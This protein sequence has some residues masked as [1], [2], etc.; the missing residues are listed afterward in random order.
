MN[1]I[2]IRYA[3]I[4][5]ETSSSGTQHF[6]G[7]VEFTN[8]ISSATK[9]K[10]LLGAW[11]VSRRGSAEEADMYCRKGEQP[12][13]EWQELKWRGP[14]FGLNADFVNAGE[15]SL[16]E[17]KRTDLDEVVSL[18]RDGATLRT[19]VDAYPVQYIKYYRGIE[20]YMRL[21]EAPR[22]EV[23]TVTVFWGSS[24]IGK[25]YR[26]RLE[27]G[28]DCY[29]WHPQQESWFDGYDAHR[30][31]IFEEFR[32]QLPYGFVLSLTDR[33]DC[34]IQ[35]KGGSCQFLATSIWFTSPV[36]P[37]EWYNNL[38]QGD[39]YTQFERRLS[40]VV[41]VDE[42]VE[43][44]R[45]KR[46]C[47]MM[48]S[49]SRAQSE[50]DGAVPALGEVGKAFSATVPYTGQS[51]SETPS[52]REFA[53]D[54]M[55]KTWM[56]PPLTPLSTCGTGTE[57]T[58]VVPVVRDFST[59]VPDGFRVRASLGDGNCLFHSLCVGQSISACDLRHVNCWCTQR[60]PCKVDW[61]CLFS[62]V[63][64][65]LFASFPLCFSLLSG[66]S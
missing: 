28:N 36:H 59:W 43:A 27:A 51:V 42:L 57:K 50:T 10:L 6:Q 26:A 65:V 52:Q 58:V 56:D 60:C 55:P 64:L 1:F 2:I 45:A 49:P 30:S 12:H 31:V 37:R 39:D 16:P 14:T 13:A 40:R 53:V 46:V 47:L 20:K 63:H 15:R 23:P 32:G 3:V 44:E 17:G 5:L 7:Y 62:L 38:T 66:S 48:K 18:I 41:H 54:E 35:Y 25:S 9:N 29:V 61:T 24:G 11:S 22:C 8:S 21:I 19:V 33:Y 34:R 4:G